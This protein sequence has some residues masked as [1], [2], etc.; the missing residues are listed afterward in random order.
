M[1]HL[2]SQLLIGV[3]RPTL[4]VIGMSGEVSEKLVLGTAAK[5]SGFQ[6]IRQIGGGPAVS[7][8]Q[9][10]PATAKDTCSRISA[11]LWGLTAALTFC[12]DMDKVTTNSYERVIGQLPG[13]LYLGAA[14]CRLI[15][16]IKPFKAPTVLDMISAAHIWKLHYNTPQGAGTEAEFCAAWKLF[17]LDSL[18]P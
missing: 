4:A 3:V 17:N 7:L 1:N 8:W 10:E 2:P 12:A 6:A 9:I 16:Y 18:W 14:L 11:H 5:E 13:N 15:Y